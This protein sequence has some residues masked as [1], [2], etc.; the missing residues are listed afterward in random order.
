MADGGVYELICADEIPYLPD[1]FVDHLNHLQSTPSENTPV[2]E[3]GK[4]AEGKRNQSVFLLCC[5]M[6]AK[7]LQ[8]DDLL[9][10]AL[11]A[12]REM[13]V[14]PMSED[15][16]MR[17][18]ASVERYSTA[19]TLD[20]IGYAERFA[21][22]FHN[23][24]KC[25]DGK[26]WLR[27]TGKVWEQSATAANECAKLLPKEVLALSNSM[28]EP[29]S[30]EEEE[31]DM[32]GQLFGH[33]KKMLNTPLAVLSIAASDPKLARRLE[34]FDAHPTL[35]NATNGVVDLKTG[36]LLP[37]DAVYL[38]TRSLRVDYKPEAQ[39]DLWSDF[40]SF[41]TDGN[42]EIEAYL[43]RVFGGIGLVD[44]NPDEV[45]MMLSGPAANGNWRSRRGKSLLAEI[46]FAHSSN[47]TVSIFIRFP[48]FG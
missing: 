41:Y 7:G 13:C 40:L 29:D 23:E 43:A 28:P 22:R 21:D 2:L 34:D 12:N 31:F 4:I 44:G 27:W 20:L 45:M 48:D 14:P 5:S 25:I 32:K 18:V 24:L 42:P 37:H 47:F 15:E 46:F 1:W 19:Y 8:G 33:A 35:I 10:F 39:S 36:E 3:N 38:M 30:V 26:L 11:W 6:R 16:V 17:I 9:R